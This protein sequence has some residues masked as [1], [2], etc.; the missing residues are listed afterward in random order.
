MYFREVVL[1]SL[2][3]KCV[4]SFVLFFFFFCL[5]AF[6]CNNIT[7]R[8]LGYYINHVIMQLIYL[9]ILYTINIHMLWSKTQKIIYYYPIV[10]Q[11][12]FLQ[13]HNINIKNQSTPGVHAVFPVGGVWTHLGGHAMQSLFSENVYK[14][15]R[16]GSYRGYAPE[17]FVIS[18]N[19]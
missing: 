6:L 7:S 16:V 19:A 9:H 2:Y 5:L 17:N 14:N 1:L 3:I 12:F 13:H 18:M 8:F 11:V 4:F 10:C 15:E